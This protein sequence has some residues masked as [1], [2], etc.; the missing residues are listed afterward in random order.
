MHIGEPVRPSDDEP[1]EVALRERMAAALDG[2]LSALR[3]E[4]R[5]Q[6]RFSVPA[7]P[8]RFVRMFGGQL[9]AQAVVAATETV[10]DAQV[11]SLHACFVAAG[12]PDVPVEVVVDR[13]RDG[14]SLS[15]RRVTVEQGE[16]ALLVALLSFDRSEGGTRHAAAAPLAPAPRDVPRLQ[17]WVPGSPSATELHAANWVDRPPPVELRIDEPPCFLGGAPGTEDR[18]HWMRLPHPVG[19]DP[20]LH[21]ALLAYASDYLLLDMALRSHPTP[22]L[23]DPASIVSLDHAV[24][25]HR[26][27]RFDRWHLHTQS[28]VA[29]AGERGL[30]RGVIH[31]ED[32][33][34]VATVVQDTLIRS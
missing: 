31:D 4:P 12:S 27:P 25:L 10:P 32:G 8:G 18:S 13:V 34:H 11:R 15:T 7:E 20:T 24:W 3:L 33:H 29:L 19:D 14:R 2:L 30:V 26:R 5:G 28:P 9:V 16:R 1:G 17:H 6:D 21:A 23:V 22:E